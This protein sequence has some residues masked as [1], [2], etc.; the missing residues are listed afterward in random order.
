MSKSEAV[1]GFELDYFD[2]YL[3]SNKPIWLKLWI[4]NGTIELRETDKIFLKRIAFTITPYD[5]YIGST[6]NIYN[7]IMIVKKYANSFTQEFMKT[8]EDHFLCVIS[9]RN[10]SSFLQLLLLSQKHALKLG[11]LTTIGFTF[12]AEFISLLGVNGA[13]FKEEL[14]YAPILDV[15][16][17]NLNLTRSNEARAIEDIISVPTFGT[18]CIIKPHILKSNDLHAILSDIKANGFDIQAMN[19]LHFSASMAEELFSA[20]RD[21]VPNYCESITQMTSSLSVALLITGF[22]RDTVSE[23]R[24]LCGP[25]VP[26]VAAAIRPSSL[27]AKY[28]RDAALNAVHCSDL[29]DYGADE[30]RYIFQTLASLGIQ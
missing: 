7:K 30:C 29:D 28:G 4:E 13:A 14:E 2:P 22:K 12:Q 27:R 5:L 24:R 21:A 11:R 18:L 17:D 25:Y 23:F 26:E 1:L 8:R 3:N 9:N 15:D 10:L 6:V 19:S 16:I 20:Y